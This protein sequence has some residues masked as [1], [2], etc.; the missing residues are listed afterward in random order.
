NERIPRITRPSVPWATV[1][2]NPIYLITAIASPD[3]TEAPSVTLSSSTFPAIGAVISFSIFIASTT[4]T[5]APAS[6][7]WPFLTLTRST[8]PWI[9][10]TTV[11]LPAPSADGP[12]RSRRGARRPPAEFPAATPPPAGGGP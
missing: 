3:A 1:G 8:V 9:G 5:T 4:H 6:T 12:E 7:S 10:D 11:P 2:G